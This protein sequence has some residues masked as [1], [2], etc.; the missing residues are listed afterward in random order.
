MPAAQGAQSLR[1]N[2]LWKQSKFPE[3]Q[4]VDT[5]PDEI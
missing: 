2:L 5:V 3:L 4:T 1:I